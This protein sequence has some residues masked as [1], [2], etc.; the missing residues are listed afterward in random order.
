MRTVR[1][2]KN[3]RILFFALALWVGVLP[4]FAAFSQACGCEKEQP[5]ACCQI[6]TEVQ[7]QSQPSCCGTQIAPEPTSKPDRHCGDCH[8]CSGQ[9]DIP[10]LNRNEA[11]KIVF[12][13]DAALLPLWVLDF[14]LLSQHIDCHYGEQANHSPPV[15][16][17]SP[18]APPVVL[19]LN[20]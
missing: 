5:C 15:Y 4:I 11:G 16:N 19:L 6:K 20:L 7:E 3:W 2:L 9:P 1:K 12:P 17:L 14:R 10:A 8:L 18:R 13:N